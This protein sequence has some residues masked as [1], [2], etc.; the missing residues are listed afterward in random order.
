MNQNIIL[1]QIDF[2]EEDDSNQDKDEMPED[3]LIIRE[4]ANNTQINVIKDE[5]IFEEKKEVDALKI[6]G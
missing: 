5:Y 4:E 2:N 1:C 6:V 3:K